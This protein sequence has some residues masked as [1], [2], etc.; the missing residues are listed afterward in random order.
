MTEVELRNL[1][2]CDFYDILAD[3]KLYSEV[4]DLDHLAIVAEEYLAE[5]NSISR[6]PMN[7]VLFRFYSVAYILSKKR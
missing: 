1:I 6:T 3:K 5:Y 4:E 2:Y 7:L